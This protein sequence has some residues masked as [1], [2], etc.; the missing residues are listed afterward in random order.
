VSNNTELSLPSNPSPTGSTASGVVFIDSRVLGSTELLAGVSTNVQVVYLDAGSDGLAQMADYLEANPGAS[1]VHV[2]AHGSP[3]NLWLGSS[4]LDSA[5][6][7]SHSAVLA[8]IGQILTADGDILVYSCDLAA[9][10]L[11]AS[12]V[13][14]L[15]ALTGADVAASTNHTGAGGDWQLEVS[16][17][18]VDADLPL[19]QQ[20]V[21]AYDLSLATLTVT[22]NL[23]QSVGASLVADIS[24]GGGL[25]IREAIAWAAASGDTITFQSGVTNSVLSLGQLTIAKSITIDGDLDNNGTADVTIDANYTSRVLSITSGTVA[26]DGLV[27]TKGLVS[28]NGGASGSSIVG[29][30]ATGAGLS[31]AGNLTLTNVSVTQNAATGSGGGGGVVG[32]SVGGGGG[33]GSGINGIGGGSGGNAGSYGGQYNGVVGGGGSGGRGGGYGSSA[34]NMG[35]RGGTSAGGGAGAVGTYGYSNGGAGSSASAGGLTIGGGGGGSGWDGNGGSGGGAAGAIYNS[36]TLTILG[37]SAITNNIAAGGGGGGGGG[38]G[39][40]AGVGGQGVGA[41]WNQG[42]TVNITAANF[43]AMSGNSGSSGTIGGV[44]NGASNSGFSS[45]SAVSNIY[46][47]GGSLNTSYIPPDVTAPVFN[48][49]AV[50]GNQLV[51]T[52]TDA[53]N[54]DATNKAGTG[55]FAVVVAGVANAVVAVTANASAKT[56]T[57]T[58]T[59]A[60]TVG[61]TVTVAYT[62]P[63]AGNDANATQDAA[64]NDAVSFGAT[65][66]TNNTP[67]PIITD[68]TYNAATGILSVTGVNLAN[69]GIIDVSKLALVGQGGGSYTLT[70]SNTTAGSSTAFAVALNAAD[71]LAVNGLL[72]NT[73]NTAVD[74]TAFNLAAA[75]NWQGTASADLA[76]NAVAV[77]NVTSPSITSAT[78]DA[79]T[80]VLTVTG[81]GMVSALGATNDITASKITLG[82]EGV[83]YTLSSSSNVEITSASSFSITLT[84][85]DIAGVSTFFNKAGTSSTGGSIYNLSVADDW[86]TVIANAN[87]ADTSNGVTVSSVPV[88]TIS[89]SGNFYNA[90][91]GTLVVTGTNLLSL[92]GGAN[93]IDVS[94]LSLTGDGDTAVALSTSSSVDITSATSFTVVLSA[95]DKAAVNLWV[96]RDGAIS[97]DVSTYRLKAA[98]NWAA[99]AASGVTDVDLI[100]NVFVAS[101]V[102]AP[103]ITSAT[104]DAS[105]GT[106]VVTGAD[107][108]HLTGAAN[109]IVVSKLSIS[110]DSSPYTLTSTHVDVTSGTSFTVMLNATDI[111]ALTSRINQD[112][113]SSMG[114]VTYNL[115]AAEDWAAGANAAVVVADLSGNGITAS[116]ASD[117]IAPTVSAITSV[118]SSGTYKISDVISIQV[119]FSEAVTVTGTPQ[120]ALETGTTDR[121]VTY[122]GGSGSSALTFNYTV[123]AGDVSADLDFTS[124]SALTLDGGTIEDAAG[125]NAILTLAAPGTAGSLADAQALVIDG[126]APIATLTAGTFASTASASVQSSEAGTAY[127]VKSTVVV[128]SIA[129]ITGAADANWNSVAVTANS[130]TPLAAT[131]LVDGSYQL[132]TA[133]AA[134][135]LSAASTVS[136]TV[137]STAPTATL[138]AGTFANTASASVQ[139]DE[140]GTAYLVNGTVVVSN[141]A[142]ITGAADANWNSVAV[143]A[144]TATPLAATGLVDGSYQLYTADAVGNLSAAS[145]VSV[146]VDSTAPTATLTAGTFANTAS[147]SVQSDEAGTAY[148]VNGTVVV[149]NVAS[150]TG[151]ADADWN[152][153]AVTANTATPLAATGLVDGSYKL[154]TADA[155]GNLSAASTASV[156]LDS[157]QPHGTLAGPPVFAAPVSNA[158]GLTD[159]GDGASPAFADIN[160]DGTLDAFVGGKDGNTQVYLNTGSAT[161]PVFAAPV[162]NAYGLTNVGSYASPTLADI[163]GDGTLDAFVGGKDGNIQ[164]YL[165]TGSA[166]HPVFGAPVTNAYGLTNVGTYASPTL[167]DINGDGLLDAFVGGNDGNTRVYLNTGSATAPVFA[168]PVINPYGLTNVGTSAS[169]TFADINGDGTLDAFVGGKDGNIQVYLNTGSA[170]NPVFAAPVTNAYGLTS[171]G[172]VASP[173]LADINGDS[174]LDAFVGGKNGNAQVFINTGGFVA[175]VTS[176]TADG[177]YGIGSVITLNVAFDENVIVTG[178]TPTLLLETGATDRAAVYTSGS[179]SSVLTFSYTVQAGDASADLDHASTAALALNGGTIRD[180]AGND[181]VLTLATPGALGSLA[182]GHALVIDTANHAPTGRIT[183]L[184]TAAQGQTL[185]ADTSTLADLDGLGTISYQW[186]AGG[187]AIAG[188]SASTLVLEQAQVG[189]VITVSASYSDGYANAESVASSATAAVANINDLP[190]GSVTMAGTAAQGRTLTANTSTL[191]DADGL[192][193]LGYQWLS[194]GAAIAGANA[195]T[196]KLVAA[197]TGASVSVQVSY[198]DGSGNH[199]TLTSSAVTPYLST[200]SSAGDD[201]LTGTSGSD[202]LMGSSGFDTAVFSGVKSGYTITR[203]VGSVTVSGA[204]GVDVLTSIE[205]LTFSDASVFL[206]P[207]NNDFDGD[208]KSD[209]LWRNTATGADTIWK[210]GNSATVQTGAAMANQ[211]EKV[212]GTGDFNADGKADILWRNTATG[213]NT[214]WKGGD[215]AAVQAVT[216]VA[217]QDWKVVGTGDFNGDGKAD[218]LWRNSATGANTIWKSGDSATVQVVTAVVNQDWKV[219]GTG[220]FDGAGDG[221]S[222]GK[223][224]ILWRNSATGANTIWKSG[225]SAAVQAVASVANLDWK[226]TA[227]GDFDGDNKAD[228]LWRNSATGADTVWKS[229]NNATVQ[230][231]AAVGNLDW[232]MIDGLATGDLLTGG[233][234]NNTLYGTVNG[235]LL[236]GGAGNDILTGGLGQD[237]FRFVNASQGNDT[238]TD[239]AA[240]VDKLQLVSSGFANL[241]LGGL[242]AGSFVSGAAPVATSASAQFLYNTGSGQVSF[243]ADGTGAGAAV[244]LVTLVGSPA[245]T[246]ADFLL[247]A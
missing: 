91:T 71:K 206:K 176:G 126:I 77:S 116:N 30:S 13:S 139:S 133:D 247:V 220:D 141:V 74:N 194:N 246:A 211:D 47:N 193:S 152:S 36:G 78:Y 129:S 85:A 172:T 199:E 12:F 57:L 205:K 127:L 92:A 145:T 163:N 52:Y 70:S 25:S 147:A 181:A 182:A 114:A 48:S 62:D 215:S 132:Y 23:D 161:N 44:T 22:T 204:D 225:D 195:S 16:T 175:P 63:S 202:T 144:N 196:Y 143:T 120:L 59:T 110:G 240:G 3:G 160:G 200:Q 55:A 26:L 104:Y 64:G 187:I 128:S 34:G 49:A 156:T 108:V 210:G 107:F 103:T 227:T 38:A 81:S 93:D 10:E 123:Q 42:G 35:G 159:V 208:G 209:I 154:Y 8:R 197:N 185:T 41:I 96:N 177:S 60:A 207:A 76:G 245:L 80:H 82:G 222:D 180:A 14:T 115:A 105:T 24:D 158:Y 101:G 33:G 73:G 21:D 235:D 166:T 189:E 241:A 212:A 231:V 131:G 121:G 117:V 58:L 223:A 151:A 6:L 11:G 98:E 244:N 148:L 218:I 119:N 124:T 228:I 40:H 84:G 134:G 90:S 136:V 150:I 69:G 46:N 7:A 233:A 125:N 203:S 28:G 43:S 230:A 4:F 72:N 178:G 20:A 142:S 239:F 232:A 122:T 75:A 19:A 167:A 111:A 130:A 39:N 183:I 94:K 9:G 149:S 86:N 135:N 5:A 18:S 102:V 1:A 32:F 100:G 217:N 2:L 213:A 214:I 50:N 66:V 237:L 15:A 99:G 67:N 164:V 162:I 174:L 87:I 83:S 79:T 236:F 112:G 53:N 179:G 157:T 234:G 198:T 89:T 173:T 186:S 113:A 229:G 191:A 54:L 29:G 106:L 137:D 97:T 37:T 192:G 201:L 118:T 168:A 171:V 224:D 45:P 138:T 17:G 190:T 238:I 243:D 170:T 155:A 221:A 242:A 216:A 68:A 153:V 65:S 140:A 219:V 56:V 146:T 165:N 184:G 27:I 51:L 31:N 169:P 61:Q 88:P 109:D 226:V 95:A 188:A